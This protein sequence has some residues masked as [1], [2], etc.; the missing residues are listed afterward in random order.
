MMKRG[1]NKRGQGVFGI[2]Y[3][4]I[5]SIIVIVFI[6]A[7]SFIVIRHF[8]DLSKC[9]DTG[10]FYDDLQNEV[11]KAWKSSFY[12]D[13]FVTRL[14]SNADFVCFGGLEEGLRYPEDRERFQTL[15]DFYRNEN[16]VYLYPPSKACDSGLGSYNLEHVKIDG[17]FCLPNNNG[18]LNVTL[19]KGNFDSLVKVG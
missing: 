5:F 19:A 1:L 9:S 2:S 12:Q 4:V 8:L 13:V 7:M 16:N 17:F 3:G 11:D 10:L 15:R 18:K 14:P 6:I